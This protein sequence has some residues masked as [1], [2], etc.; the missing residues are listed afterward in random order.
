MTGVRVGAGAATGAGAASWGAA[1][2]GAVFAGAS[3]GVAAFWVAAFAAAV[4]AG[5]R[6][7]R[8]EDVRV[9][10]GAPVGVP[11]GTAVGAAVGDDAG[12]GLVAAPVA[13]GSGLAGAGLR[14]PGD[15]RLVWPDLA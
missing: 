15:V 2:S 9:G 8:P 13:V 10:A 3:S 5:E 12:V 1:V 14:G 11:V 4:F 7:A 6:A